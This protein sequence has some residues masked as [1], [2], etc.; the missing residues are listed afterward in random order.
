MSTLNDHDLTVL[1]EVAASG[2]VNSRAAHHGGPDWEAMDAGAKNAV[3]EHAL[4]F[5]YHGTQALED[6]GYS[7]PRTV[8]SS[9]EMEELFNSDANVI[10]MDM[11]GAVIQN[12]AGGWKSPSSDRFMTSPMAHLVHGPILTVLSAE[13]VG[14]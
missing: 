14:A 7:K 3:R 2:A 11:D 6:L 9:A 13:A 12:L 1:V 10:L 8:M 4:P 5:I